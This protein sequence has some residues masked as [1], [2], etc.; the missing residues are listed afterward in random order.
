MYHVMFQQEAI[1]GSHSYLM[2]RRKKEKVNSL[3]TMA[4]QKNLHRNDNNFDC[5]IRVL[6]C[7]VNVQLDYL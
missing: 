6:C 7:Q 3:N 2:H 1:C 4:Q 5:H